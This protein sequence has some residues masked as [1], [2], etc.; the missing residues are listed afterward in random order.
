ME[1][2]FS[3]SNAI[4]TGWQAT[5]KDWLVFVGLFLAVMVISMLISVP[6]LIFKNPVITAISYVI[7]FIF[8]AICSAGLTTLYI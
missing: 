4:F 2:S 1:Q 8:S 7:S 3:I 6:E 5:K